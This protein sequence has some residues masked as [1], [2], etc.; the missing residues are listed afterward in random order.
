MSSVGCIATV[1]VITVLISIAG[2]RVAIGMIRIIAIAVIVGVV[3]IAICAVCI[4][5]GN[6]RIGISAPAFCSRSR[7][8]NIEI[9]RQRMLV[10]V[11]TES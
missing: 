8:H 5:I 7:S 10:R 1:V 6:S 3:D 9:R 11:C 2:W 4:V